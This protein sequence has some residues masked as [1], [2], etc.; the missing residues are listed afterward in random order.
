VFAH[1]VC[2]DQERIGHGSSRFYVMQ[3][4]SEDS[5]FT[6]R[7][8]FNCDNGVNVFSCCYLLPIPFLPFLVL[9]SAKHFH[10]SD[11]QLDDNGNLNGL[12]D[13]SKTFEGYLVIIDQT[14]TIS[15]TWH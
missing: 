3:I 10:S 5:G 9:S 15:M 2:V 8:Y 1:F 4:D 6:F 11:S 12:T 14:I 7:L 13:F